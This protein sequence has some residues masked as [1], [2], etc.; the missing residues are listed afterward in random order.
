[1]QIIEAVQEKTPAEIMKYE[2]KSFFL[3][4]SRQFQ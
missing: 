4:H 1:M 2:N 3:E